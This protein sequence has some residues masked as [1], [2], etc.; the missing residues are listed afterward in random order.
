MRDA[1]VRTLV[2]PRR[3]A[4]DAIEQWLLLH[5]ADESGEED[6]CQYYIEALENA[7]DRVSRMNGHRAEVI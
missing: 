7:V 2:A 1:E 6:Q 4:S 3:V 5:P